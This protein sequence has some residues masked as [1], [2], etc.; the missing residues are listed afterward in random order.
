ME[1]KEELEEAIKDRLTEYKEIVFGPGIY[2][3]MTCLAELW[4]QQVMDQKVYDQK[5]IDDT[6]RKL[7]QDRLQKKIVMDGQTMINR[8]TSEMLYPEVDFTYWKNKL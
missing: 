8:K 2:A 6:M 7:A 4:K 3:C 5:L 1:T